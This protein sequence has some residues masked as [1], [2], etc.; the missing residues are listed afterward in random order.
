LA[1]SIVNNPINSIELVETAYRLD[2]PARKW[3]LSVCRVLQTW[4][5]E[6]QN[7]FAFYVD[8]RHGGQ[9]M[10]YNPLSL[11]HT[12]QAVDLQSL[13]EVLDLQSEEL[14]AKTMKFVTSCT[15][16]ELPTQIHQD[17]VARHG[18]RFGAR[19][20][21]ML[22]T[23]DNTGLGLS[24]V[25]LLPRRA[26]TPQRIRKVWSQ[27]AP[28]LSAALRI[29]RHLES[30]CQAT[31]VTGQF[32]PGPDGMMPLVSVLNSLSESAR[33]SRSTSP[34]HFRAL[35]QDL[36]GGKCSLV[37]Q[38]QSAEHHFLVLR[39]NEH[40]TR[41]PRALTEREIEIL[42]HAASGDTDRHIADEL[43]V[44]NSTVATHRSRGVAKLGLKSRAL[45]CQLFN[46][47]DEGNSR[48]ETHEVRCG[49]QDVVILS[50]P[51]LD[52]CLPQDLTEA[53]R[54]IACFLLD[55]LSNRDIAEIR[56]TS[57]RT[58]ANQAAAA[59]RKIGV[60]RRAELGDGLL[61]SDEPV[62]ERVHPVVNA[63]STA[64]PVMPNNV[65]PLNPSSPTVASHAGP[66]PSTPRMAP[67][68]LAWAASPIG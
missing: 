15:L 19:D 67:A 53:E 4:L 10:A 29:R 33:Q 23:N 12:G 17:W 50:A 22:S 14:V 18:E 55:G 42:R 52:A 46:Q 24:I 25:V 39:R 44:S 45:L 57:V 37:H 35:W 36:M 9:A 66:P 56:G 21:L 38:H 48:I 47:R 5:P 31:S 43:S 64:H 40:H 2:L 49:T 54:T 13:P 8:T 26:R 27:C 1:P 60:R 30:L 34:T 32:A 51:R 61:H 11:S 20:A 41:D 63:A 3:L 59:L 62:P 16:S 6:H 65:T 7:I 28:H 68:A 58:V